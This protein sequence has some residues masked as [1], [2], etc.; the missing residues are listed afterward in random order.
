MRINVTF[1]TWQANFDQYA[2]LY[3]M[4]DGVFNADIISVKQ[5]EIASD[6]EN[7]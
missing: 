2:W 3:N 6:I 7:T 1:C 5:K 4:H